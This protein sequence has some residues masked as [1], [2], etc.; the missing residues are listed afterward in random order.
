M[1]KQRFWKLFR[2][3]N[4]DFVMER[5][6]IAARWMIRARMAMDDVSDDEGEVLDAA[7]TVMWSGLDSTYKML[8]NETNP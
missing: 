8:D 7:L 2:Q 6:E 3:H 5:R 1:L 4:D